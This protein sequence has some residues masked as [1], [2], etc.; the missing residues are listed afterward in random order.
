VSSGDRPHGD[1][2]PG[3]DRGGRGGRPGGGGRDRGRGGR[4]G[5]PGGGDGIAVG[6][7]DRA[8]EDTRNLP[9][10]TLMTK[11][12]GES[13]GLSGGRVPAEFTS[14]TPIQ[15]RA[16]PNAPRSEKAAAVFM[17]IRVA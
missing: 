4:G 2:P 17:P 6:A 1:R 14:R 16:N 12:H 7:A 13:R 8:G 3:G 9:R 10:I 5:R 11:G 15:S